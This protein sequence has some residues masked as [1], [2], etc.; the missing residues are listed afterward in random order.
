MKGGVREALAELH[1]GL[2]EAFRHMERYTFTPKGAREMRDALAEVLAA[3]MLAPH[4]YAAVEGGAWLPW[5]PDAPFEYAMTL[6]R[7]STSVRMGELDVHS[8]AF[9]EPLVGPGRFLRWDCI[10]GYNNEVA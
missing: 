3:P 1:R 7:S 8:I 6:Q 4:V 9:G 10:N 2:D 5:P